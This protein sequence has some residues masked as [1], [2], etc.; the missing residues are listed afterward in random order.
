MPVPS[1]VTDL[2]IEGISSLSGTFFMRAK[3]KDTNAFLRAFKNSK[4][5]S[6]ETSTRESDPYMA[7]PEKVHIIPYALSVGWEEVEKLKNA[8]YYAFSTAGWLGTLVIDRKNNVI[9]MNG[10]EL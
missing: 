6:L 8:E 1:G 5:L 3:V 9:Y 2:R 7:Q 10:N 4:S